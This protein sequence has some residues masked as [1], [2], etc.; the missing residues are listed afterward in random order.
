MV[1]P[2]FLA[3]IS[4]SELHA[5]VFAAIGPERQPLLIGLD[6]RDGHGKT[7]AANWLAWQFG[8]PALHLD[9]FTEHHDYTRAMEWRSVDLQ[10]C[11]TARNKRPI[12]IEGVL[13]LDALDTIGRSPD[14]FVFVE[15]EEPGRLRDRSLDNDLQDPREFCLSNQV[16]RYFYRRNPSNLADFRLAWKEEPL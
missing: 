16:S 1:S 4:Y 9:L 11:L 14:F 2:P 10:R 13:L 6:G 7:S 5:H 3:P 15:R 8:M 12:I